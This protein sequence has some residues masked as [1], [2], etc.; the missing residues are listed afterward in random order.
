M[1]V[2]SGTGHNAETEAAGNPPALLRTIDDLAALYET[3]HVRLVH[4]ARALTASPTL[5]EEIV[6]EAFI[7]VYEK[8]ASVSAPAGYLRQVVVNEC[9]SRTRRAAVERSK[10][11]ILGRRPEPAPSPEPGVREEILSTLSDLPQR[12]RTAIVLRFYEDLSVAATAELMGVRQGTVK[13]LV[14][15]GLQA[16]KASI[17]E[18]NE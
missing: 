5:A 11:E 9:H 3:E 13:S 2:K 12:Q 4:L 6:Q 8:R 1:D 10:L 14:H 16:L 7:K 15:R 17:E 18:S